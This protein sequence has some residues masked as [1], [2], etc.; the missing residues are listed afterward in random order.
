MP[1]VLH[2]NLHRQFFAAIAAGTKRTEY[3]AAKPYWRTRLEGRK[4]DRIL[5]RN[6]YAKDAPEMLVELRRIR[7]NGTGRGAYY[8]ISLGKVLNVKRWRPSQGSKA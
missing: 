8:A 5:F 1:D 7:K 6:G 4:Y 2:L 3:R